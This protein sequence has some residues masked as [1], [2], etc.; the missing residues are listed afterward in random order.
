M[1]EDP[2]AEEI[3]KSNLHE[4]D[5]IMIDYETGKEDLIVNIVKGK[6]DT[7]SKKSDHTE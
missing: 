1:I 3:V 5:S 6:K 7:K 2:L 4:G